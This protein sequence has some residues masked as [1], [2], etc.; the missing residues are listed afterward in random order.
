MAAVVFIIAATFLFVKPCLVVQNSST[1]QIY[2]QWLVSDN[3][4]F[5]IE[6]VHSVN[7]TPV[8][9][10]FLI[11]NNEFL[12]TETVFYGFGAG[13]QTE[14]EE[15]QHLTYNADSSMSITG[16]T[17]RLP[18]LNYIIGTVSDHVLYIN[19]ESISLRELCGKN[20]AIT[21]KT[22]ERIWLEF[23]KS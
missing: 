4:E 10:V 21:I 2:A 13:M 15:G 22:E 19:G 7:Q 12:P 8:R 1:G 17:M 3:S 20:A 6:F 23:G 11:S 9:D 5:S 18:Q 16:F 14:L